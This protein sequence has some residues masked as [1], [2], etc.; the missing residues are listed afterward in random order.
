MIF[1]SFNLLDSYSKMSSHIHLY[2]RISSVLKSW[3][4]SFLCFMSCSE[5][6]ELTFQELYTTP[7]FKEV[8]LSEIFDDSKTFVD[9][10]PN[11]PLKVI[12]NDYN[13]HATDFNLKEFVYQ[14]FTIP[15]KVAIPSEVE[16]SSNLEAHINNLWKEL[17]RMDRDDFTNNSLICLLNPGS[18]SPPASVSSAL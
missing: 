8:Q 18:T 11:R 5:P 9:A 2:P 13:T 14:N 15:Q 4:F 12:L 7:F 16:S 3:A 17:T 1:N 10:V 6:E